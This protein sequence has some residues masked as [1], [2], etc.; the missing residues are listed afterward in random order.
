MLSEVCCGNEKVD[1]LTDRRFVMLMS[2]IFKCP[3]R[4]ERLWIVACLGE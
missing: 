2:G 1:E 3:K 4:A